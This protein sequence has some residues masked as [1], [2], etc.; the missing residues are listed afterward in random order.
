MMPKS[1]FLDNNMV[2]RFIEISPQVDVISQLISNGYSLK[3]NDD[4]SIEMDQLIEN[5]K[6]DPALRDFAEK[7]SGKSQKVSFFG[8]SDSDGQCA[9]NIGGFEVGSFISNEQSTYLKDNPVDANNIRKKTKIAKNRTDIFLAS[10]AQ[11]S[12]VITDNDS[13][14]HWKKAHENSEFPYLVFWKELKP[15]YEKTRY[16]LPKSLEILY[17]KIKK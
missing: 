5:Q 8:F 12:W 15:L 13:E 2:N 9:A 16:N 6:K 1:I 17:D 7:Y 4:L 11:N 10:Y 14:S 3:T